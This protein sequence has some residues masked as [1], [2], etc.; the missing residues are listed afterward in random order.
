MALIDVCCNVLKLSDDG[1][2]LS[3][4]DLKFIENVVNYGCSEEGEIYLYEMEKKLENKTYAKNW[5]YDVEDL[6]QDHEGYIY[7]KGIHVEHYSHSNYDNAR[8]D[9]LE[10]RD[11]CKTLEKNNIPVNCANAIWKW[12]DHDFQQKAV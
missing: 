1:E 12:G 8:K 7:Y 11:R 5:A 2:D 10:L 6:T 3:P 9:A 4:R